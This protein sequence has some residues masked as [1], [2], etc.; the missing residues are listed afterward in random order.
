MEGEKRFRKVIWGEKLI[1]N[2]PSLVDDGE[3]T[4]VL[5]DGSQVE[6]SNGLTR[7]IPAS[8]NGPMHINELGQPDPTE[9]WAVKFE[10][11]PSMCQ[12][13]DGSARL[14][15]QFFKL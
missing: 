12:R 4:R 14:I 3:E 11:S 7:P 6:V 5:D 1:L 15:F 13:P 8:L 2:H 9:E 10:P